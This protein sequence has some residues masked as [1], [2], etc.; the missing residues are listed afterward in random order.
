[1]PSSAIAAPG[2]L[3]RTHVRAHHPP[4]TPRTTP[5]SGLTPVS[6]ATRSCPLASRPSAPT[7]VNRLGVTSYLSKRAIEATLRSLP[8]ALVAVTHI[9]PAGQYGPGPSGPGASLAFKKLAGEGRESVKA[10][11]TSDAFADL[12]ASCG[13]RVVESAGSEHVASRYGLPV[14]SCGDE[15][16]VLA[17]PLGRA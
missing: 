5:P 6:L 17:A 7:F 2:P 4:A 10:A 12:L 14:M 8:P 9:A 3:R 13:M 11:F 1:M 15:Q 16:I